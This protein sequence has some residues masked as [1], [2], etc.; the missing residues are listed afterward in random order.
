MY[1]QWQIHIYTIYMLH[2]LKVIHYYELVIII[3]WQLVSD[4]L[5]YRISFTYM[6]IVHVKFLYCLLT[7]IL[8]VEVWLKI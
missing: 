4:C 2:W 5:K 7:S 3:N 6:Y 1:S 8:N